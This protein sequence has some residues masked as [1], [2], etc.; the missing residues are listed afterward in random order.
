MAC[1]CWNGN[2]GGARKQP[3]S[4]IFMNSYVCQWSIWYFTGTINR[5]PGTLAIR[6]CPPSGIVSR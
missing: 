6:P 3:G 4:G 2:G 5:N 1:A